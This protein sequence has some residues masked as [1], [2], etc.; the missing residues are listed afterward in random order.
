MRY[1]KLCVCIV[2]LVFSCVGTGCDSRSIFELNVKK[3][4][5]TII[6]PF[7]EGLAVVKARKGYSYGYID[8]TG[9]IVIPPQFSEAWSFSEGLAAV[10]P[11][12]R[13]KLGYINSEGKYLI[14]AQFDAGRRFAEGLALVIR[15]GV[16]QYIDKS[17]KTAIPLEFDDGGDFSGGMARVVKSGL[18]GFIDKSGRIVVPPAYVKAG[19]FSEGLAFVC[20]SAKCGFVDAEGQ[21][22]ISLQFDDAKSFSHG[23]APV[24]VGEHW[25]YINVNGEWHVPAKF[26]EAHEYTEGLALVGQ[27]KDSAYNSKYGGYS[28]RKTFY[29]FLDLAGRLAIDTVIQRAEPFADGRAM[30]KVPAAFSFLCSDCYEFRFIDREENMMP[31]RYRRAAGFRD[32]RAIVASERGT[33]LINADGEVLVE[34]DGDSL[35]HRS[36]VITPSVSRQRDAS[37]SVGPKKSSHAAYGYINPRGENVIAHRFSWAKPFSDGLAYVEELGGAWRRMFINKQGETAFELPQEFSGVEPFA[38]GLAVFALWENKKSKY[39][40]IDTAGQIKIPAQFCEADSFSEGLAAVKTD[41]SSGKNNVQY[42]DHAGGFAFNAAFYQANPFS[43]GFAFVSLLQNGERGLQQIV[44]ALIDTSGKV[45]M[46]N[47]DL[48]PLAYGPLSGSSGYESF[49]KKKAFS[50]KEALFP[51]RTWDGK[52]GLVGYVNAG[53]SFVIPPRFSEAQLFSEG[54]AAVSAG[55]KWGYIN[56]HGEAVIEARFVKALP[57]KEGMALIEDET[58]KQGYV[59]G[60]G[61]WAIAPRFLEEADSFAGGLALVKLNGFYG[62]MDKTGKMAIEPQYTAAHVFSE[63]LA[64]VKK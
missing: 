27:I 19:D 13:K 58:G 38:D 48:L 5:V 37:L 62:Y 2:L 49:V 45:V 6:R 24:K 52:R 43:G 26:D 8:K 20:S 47:P 18:A 29:G 51:K 12:Q 14:E 28:G 33:Y 30:I 22:R 31:G 9:A 56:Q 64:A 50:F 10:R 21:E 46:N 1:P 54:F 35:D 7:S 57:F 59:Q 39:G 16:L 53:G 32:S 3:V 44:T 23:F 17:G 63:G 61:E 25:G 60:S 15:E 55:G 41:C 11:P 40:Y 42:I 4:G 34:V 36:Q